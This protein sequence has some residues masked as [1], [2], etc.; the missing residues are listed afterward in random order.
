MLNKADCV[1]KF[2]FHEFLTISVQRFLE[3]L[4][5]NP[6]FQVIDKKCHRKKGHLVNFLKNEKVGKA[7]SCIFGI[8]LFIFCLYTCFITY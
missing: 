5:K 4:V 1:V 7:I 2:C 3:N 6:F 8:L